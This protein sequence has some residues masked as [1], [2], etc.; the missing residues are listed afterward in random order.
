MNSSRLKR[1]RS[2]SFMNSRRIRNEREERKSEM[3]HKK[4]RAVLAD[5]EAIIIKGLRKLIDWCS[6]NVEIVGE[7]RT[8][9]EVMELI[10]TES[11]DLVISDICM[12]EMTGLD[13][14]KQISE[15]SP[16]VKVIFI[17][18]Y[19]EF[20]Y[21]K[22]AVTYGAVDYI[23]K[24]VQK[25]KLENA[26]K[27][28]LN[29]ITEEKKLKVFEP[30]ETEEMYR[31]VVKGLRGKLDA[32]QLYEEFQKLHADIRGKDTLTAGIRLIFLKNSAEN[33][34]LNELYAF[35]VF[36]RI[37]SELKNRGWGFIVKKDNNTCYFT[38]IL[39]PEETAQDV[40]SKLN[41]VLHM[42]RNYDQYA[43]KAGIGAR[44]SDISQLALEYDTARFA[45]ELYYFT[46]EDI[47]WYDRIQREFKDSLDD[48]ENG[49]RRLLV[50]FAEGKGDHKNET[51]NILSVIRN[52]HFG[53]RFAAANRCI[54]LVHERTKELRKLQIL[55][56]SFD[57]IEEEIEMEI[58]KKGLFRLAC[59]C[60]TE[61][62]DRISQAVREGSGNEQKKEIRR[63]EKYLEEH[64]MEG[65]SLESMAEV[66]SMNPY[67]FSSY[68][69]KNM[70]ENFKTYLTELRMTRA[71]ILLR[72]TDRKTYQIAREVGYKNVRQFNENFKVKYGMSPS[73]YRKS[74]E[75]DQK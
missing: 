65:I 55:D 59:S 56:E 72:T 69:K 67:Y 62:F 13:M 14:L 17:S 7:A 54:L 10:E 48:Y 11:P 74:N 47:I 51:G 75:K 34:K 70:G 5:D 29:M 39:E 71:E 30:V 37:H 4:Y 73:E 46:E 40:E 20:S 49:F 26:V 64:Y 60:V 1:E 36:N 19:Q 25:D 27:K 21:A 33:T 15:K 43:V 57:R 44:G 38:L 63:I 12:P 68:F 52:L 31:K 23:L 6:L 2:A 24:P 28:A 35:S 50:C 32:D 66:F 41:Q 61:Y 45:L 18:G 3:S 42:I 58:R 22:D 53:N 16:A 8:G 9:R